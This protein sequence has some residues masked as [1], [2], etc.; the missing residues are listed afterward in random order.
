MLDQARSPRSVEAN[1]FQSRFD[2]FR[3]LVR[4]APVEIYRIHYPG[5]VDR[6]R[7]AEAAD[8]ALCGDDPNPARGSAG[9]GSRDRSNPCHSRPERQA[10]KYGKYAY[11]HYYAGRYYKAIMPTDEIGNVTAELSERPADRSEIPNTAATL[12]L[13]STCNSCAV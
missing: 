7:D 5:R 10:Q 1:E 2:L 13:K 11:S 6:Q 4:L 12:V 3:Y 8:T 9:K